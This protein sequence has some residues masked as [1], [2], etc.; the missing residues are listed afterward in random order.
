MQ[1][2]LRREDGNLGSVVKDVSIDLISVD[3]LQILL[4]LDKRVMFFMMDIEGGR[5][6]TPVR[7]EYHKPF[8]KLID[9]YHRCILLV[10]YLLLFSI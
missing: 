3:L 7:L 1:M 8:Y 4:T 9:G 10:T 5:A 6:I 2:Y